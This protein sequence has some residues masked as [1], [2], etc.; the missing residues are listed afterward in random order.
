MIRTI[1]E[2]RAASDE[3][4]IAEHDRA[5]PSTQVGTGYYATS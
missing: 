3:E 1:A 4:L 2:L 5:A